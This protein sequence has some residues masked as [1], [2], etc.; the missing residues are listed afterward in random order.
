MILDLQLSHDLVPKDHFL[1]V[2]KSGSE[3]EKI[4]NFTSSEIDLCNYRVRNEESLM[5]TL[6]KCINFQSFR[7]KFE[8]SLNHQFSLK[9]VTE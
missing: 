4:S 8:E 6:E 7:G 9:H 1:M 2:Q 3:Y 5:K